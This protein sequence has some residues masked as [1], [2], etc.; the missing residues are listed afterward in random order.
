MVEYTD[1]S[2]IAQVPATDMRMPIQ[3]AMTWPERSDAPVPRLDWTQSAHW[4]FDPPDKEKFPL[5]EL[6]I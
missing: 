4:S 2:V 3:Y 5:L 1:G 6:G